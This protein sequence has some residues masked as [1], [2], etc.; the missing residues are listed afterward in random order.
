VDFKNIY[1]WKKHTSDIPKV[2][3]L[4]GPSEMDLIGAVEGSTW[5]ILVMTVAL[6]VVLQKAPNVGS[7]N[8]AREGIYGMNSGGVTGAVIGSAVG[9]IGTVLGGIF[10]S[11][12]GITVGFGGTY[13][14]QHI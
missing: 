8:M 3:F 4:G 5:L 1:A 7:V 9:P 12:L 14:A 6:A 2:Q 11:L 10:G 13:L